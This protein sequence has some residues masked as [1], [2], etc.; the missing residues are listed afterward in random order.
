MAKPEGTISLKWF[1]VVN[2]YN[3][4]KDSKGM[5]EFVFLTHPLGRSVREITLKITW[6]PGTWRF[7]GGSVLCL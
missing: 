4:H 7:L 2:G 5:I 3:H 6:V 1:L